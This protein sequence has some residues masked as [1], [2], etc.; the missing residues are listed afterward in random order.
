MGNIADISHAAKDI[1]G[2]A[3]RTVRVE[4]AKGAVE[5]KRDAVS[6]TASVTR[7]DTAAGKAVRVDM[8]P[9]AF[10]SA[11]VAGLND[12]VRGMERAGMTMSNIADISRTAKDITGKTPRTVRIET[13]AG[14]LEVRQDTAGVAASVIHTD[15]A[16]GRTVTMD[17]SQQALSDAPMAQL[18]K[19]VETLE[20]TVADAPMAGIKDINRTAENITGQ[21]PRAVRIE[22]GN[23]V[24]EYASGADEGTFRIGTRDISAGTGIS[25]G[26]KRDGKSGTVL[27]AFDGLMESMAAPDIA[28][29]VKKA[30][31][32]DR[33]VSENTGVSPI[34]V[35]VV[36]DGET[37]K[38]TKDTG[39]NVF[40]ASRT[41]SGETAGVSV[42][43]GRRE[44]LDT[45]FVSALNEILRNVDMTEVSS[46]STVKESL[47]KVLAQAMSKNAEVREVSAETASGTKF[48]G[49]YEKPVA[50]T[51][52]RTIS[53]KMM[54]IESMEVTS[55]ED[56]AGPPAGMERTET[57][58]LGLTDRAL[59]SMGIDKEAKTR[60]ETGDMGARELSEKLASDINM[61][62][63]DVLRALSEAVVLKAEGRDMDRV[64]DTVIAARVHQAPSVETEALIE[65]VS[66]KAGVSAERS[67]EIIRNAQAHSALSAGD[68]DMVPAEVLQQAADR[69]GTP[70]A[71]KIAALAETGKTPRIAKEA[72]EKIKAA[73][74]AADKKT[75][76]AVDIREDAGVIFSAGEKRTRFEEK[77]ADSNLTAEFAAGVLNNGN[78]I[79]AELVSA[80]KL[81]D[82]ESIEAFRQ[83]TRAMQKMDAVPTAKGR[84]VVIVAGTAEQIAGLKADQSMPSNVR[85][86]D[87]AGMTRSSVENLM[88]SGLTERERNTLDKK[89]RGLVNADD[90]FTGDF[91]AIVDSLIVSDASFR[92]VT[93]LYIDH[94]ARQKDK[95]FTIFTQKAID[96]LKSDVK[97]AESAGMRVEVVE[98]EDTVEE[99]DS[100]LETSF[101]SDVAF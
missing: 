61:D 43:F 38:V 37:F 48:S 5:V 6:G 29:P 27:K 89:I 65:A 53:G 19:I 77:Y 94:I 101:E 31:D 81:A 72:G 98:S 76:D 73:P 57:F 54:D 42:E 4:T 51:G 90:P 63:S 68:A 56:I 12:M 25:A 78:V 35:D 100:A 9:D 95:Y 21:A 87:I 22:S 64:T 91:T 58:E 85:F 14:A 44:S 93:M 26:F 24:Y 84:H 41:I 74:E 11:P 52:Q 47:E 2:H 1:T 79:E 39:K 50:M 3:P 16:A 33:A 97:K 69:P 82:S 40:R 36:K 86:V 8:A 70:L 62:S 88:N 18:D 55:A 32:I 60:I 28:D 46:A 30:V 67:Q 71:E 66:E 75:T 7:V 83:H 92:T 80:N 23:R 45:S 59:A 17:I 13:A 20:R 15:T 99:I 34:D 96:K 49:S 10:D